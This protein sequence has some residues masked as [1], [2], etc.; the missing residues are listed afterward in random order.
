MKSWCV[1]ITV[2]LAFQLVPQWFGSV[3]RFSAS[4]ISRSLIFCSRL[5]FFMIFRFW[6]R[7]YL[8]TRS[9]N[10]RNDS[11]FTRSDNDTTILHVFCGFNWIGWYTFILCWFTVSFSGSH[12]SVGNTKAGKVFNK[13][14]AMH[15][16]IFLHKSIRLQPGFEPTVE[17]PTVARRLKYKHT[18]CKW[19]N[20]KVDLRQKLEKTLQRWLFSSP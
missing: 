12:V 1:L 13:T 8:P 17:L 10:W 20:N 9:R 15:L 5:S 7:G 19:S 18:K 3:V 6:F 16:E 2:I 14:P 11:Q 4:E